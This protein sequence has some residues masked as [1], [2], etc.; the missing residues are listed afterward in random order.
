MYK[1]LN[2]PSSA[3]LLLLAVHA[4]REPGSSVDLNPTVQRGAP[5]IPDGYI[6]T[7]AGLYHQSC[8][9]E[10][11]SGARIENHGIVRRRDGTTYSLPVCGYPVLD[12]RTNGPLVPADNG[13]ME[14]A[15][16]QSVTAYRRLEA[17]WTVPAKPT[18]GYPP[19]RVY[20]TFPGLQRQPPYILQPVLQFGYNGA[21]G[22]IFVWTLASWHCN[23]T[24]SGCAY[25]SPIQTTVGH[26]LHGTVSASAC[27]GGT[28][29]WTVTTRDVTTG[30]ATVLTLTDPDS[31]YFG[32]GGAVEVYNLTLCSQ[33]PVNGVFYTG[34][35]VFDAFGQVSPS[36]SNSLAV[37]PD[38]SCGFAVT[39]TSSTVSLFHN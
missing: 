34:L 8:V 11:E 20:Y 17:D 2:Y 18:G 16:S 30:S 13:W 19:G 38:P 4:C 29:T 12:W 15:Q 36:W 35:Q 7:P 37:N 31:Y 1:R 10:I 27:A 14:S 5:S 33:Y 24:Q 9:H 39:S 25:S 23:G 32:V 26:T 3:V 22:G 6:Q 28:C 21:F